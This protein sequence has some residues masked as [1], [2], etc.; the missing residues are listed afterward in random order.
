M[1]TLSDVPSIFAARD[2]QGATVFGP[3]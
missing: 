2:D 3:S 1:S